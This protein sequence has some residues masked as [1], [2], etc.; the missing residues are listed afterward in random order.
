[1]IKNFSGIAYL[2]FKSWTIFILK[3]KPSKYVTNVQPKRFV[4][5]AIF[6]QLLRNVR[7]SEIISQTIKKDS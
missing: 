4:Q 3:E 7:L 1:M 2:I 5:I 6:S